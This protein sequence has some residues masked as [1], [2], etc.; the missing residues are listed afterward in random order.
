MKE[1]RTKEG[2]LSAKYDFLMTIPPNFEQAR[3]HGEANA[4]HDKISPDE[5][6]E[7]CKCCDKH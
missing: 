1:N 4:I 7:Q 5:D 2:E 6:D 3:I